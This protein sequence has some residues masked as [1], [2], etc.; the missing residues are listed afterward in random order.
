MTDSIIKKT[1]RTLISAVLIT[2]FFTA[3][4]MLVSASGSDISPGSK[5]VGSFVVKGESAALSLRREQGMLYA[6]AAPV[7]Y[8]GSFYSEIKND[9]IAKLVYD[10]LYDHCITH[11]AEGEFDIDVNPEYMHKENYASTIKSYHAGFCAFLYDHPEVYWIGINQ[12]RGFVSSSQTPEGD[13]VE[14][15]TLTISP[16]ETYTGAFNQRSTVSNGINNAVAAI[17]PGNTR[18]DTLKNIHDYICQ[19]SVYDDDEAQNG[20]TPESHTPAPLF[21]GK[22][23]YVCEGYAKAFK[24]LCDQFNIPCVLVCGMGITNTGS[25]GHMWNYVQMDDGNETEE[26]KW[27]AVD[28]TWDDQQTGIIYNWFLKGSNTVNSDHH[29]DKPI[30][31][32]DDGEQESVELYYPQLCMADYDPSNA[33]TSSSSS[34]ASSSSSSASTITTANNEPPLLDVTLDN[35]N[36]GFVKSAKIPDNAVAI[37]GN[38]EVPLNKLKVIVTPLNTTQKKSLTD[39]IYKINTSFDPDNS[40]LVVCDI[41]IV[42]DNG[43]P[44][45]FTEGKVKIC[46]AFP[47]TLTEKY[48]N[49]VYSVYHQK[50]DGSVERVKPVNYNAQG[51]WFETNNFSSF[52]MT[53]ISASTGEPS[54]G[55]GET[56]TLTVVAIALLVLAS[57]AI[58]FVL[59]KGRSSKRQ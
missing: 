42:D 59:V 24:I 52:G 38:K 45:T 35:P 34:S 2:A 46:L 54:P 55:T 20:K 16:K 37:A 5:T 51:V 17:S 36:N 7:T 57:A 29:A 3:A 30:V 27:Y 26:D 53:G 9:Y 21:N 44:V 40:N 33:T 13:I 8:N 15:A 23:T 18:Y 11:P 1:L 39:G 50:P 49:Y 10:G 22:G 48:Y 19:H 6:N 25:E 41:K 28:V 43:N 14:T 47:S 31:I 58:A 56:I 4:G 32:N 12:I